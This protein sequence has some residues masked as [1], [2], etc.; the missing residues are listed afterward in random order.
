MARR[1]RAAVR[2]LTRDPRGPVGRDLARRALRVQ[3]RAR[4]LAPVRHGRLRSSI[5]STDVR[6]APTGL[7]VQVGSDLVYALAVHE[8]STSP[9]APRSW[10]RGRRV[11]ARRYLTNALPAA[12]T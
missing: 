10:R 4:I 11:P 5:T 2:L 1:N 12:R 8:G 9:Y 7:T 3:N 6:P